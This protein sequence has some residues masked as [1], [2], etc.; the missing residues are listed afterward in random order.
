MSD[1]ES[2]GFVKFDILGVAALDKIQGVVSLLRG[3]KART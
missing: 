2:M 1:L 3:G